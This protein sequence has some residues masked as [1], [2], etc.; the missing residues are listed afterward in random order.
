MKN[1]LERVA[2]LWCENMHG[3]PLW[4]SHGHYQCRVCL[5][6]YPVPFET[7]VEENRP[8]R[9]HA[10]AATAVAGRRA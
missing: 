6:Q 8:R 10:F 4:P 2:E 7:A 3:Q 9:E 1:L 5:R